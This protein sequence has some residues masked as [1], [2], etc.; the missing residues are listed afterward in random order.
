MALKLKDFARTD[1]ESDPIRRSD[2]SEDEDISYLPTPASGSTKR[3]RSESSRRESSS[4]R[5]SS[6]PPRFD[7]KEEKP[8]LGPPAPGG[9]GSIQIKY[10]SE[11]DGYDVDSK[12]LAQMES[13]GL[14]TG[15]SFSQA[16][17]A[18]EPIISE[19]QKK[20]DKKTFW[21]EVCLII[22]FQVSII[23]RIKKKT[24]ELSI[25]KPQSQTWSL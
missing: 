17:P 23:F 8:F 11:I 6:S 4:R 22:S 13:L 5:D 15:F 21:C 19:K 18:R 14:P 24:Q 1:I 10:P 20:G 12:S 2:E 3:K 7:R 16:T 25:S 9:D